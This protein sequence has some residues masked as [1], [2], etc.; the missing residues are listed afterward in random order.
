M[1]IDDEGRSAELDPIAWYFHNSAQEFELDRGQGTHPVALKQANPW[2]LYDML[3]NVWE[4]TADAWQNSYEEAPVDGSARPGQPGAEGVGR[5]VR[6]GSWIDFAG[7]ARSAVRRG[8][9]PGYRDDGLG[10]RCA[11]VQVRS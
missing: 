3:G 9:V 2:G 8:F 7:Y 10:L 11:R 4:W 5:V 6:G 1:A